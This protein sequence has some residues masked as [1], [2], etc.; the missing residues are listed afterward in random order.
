MPPRRS[1]RI[2]RSASEELT[3][4][5]SGSM[6]TGAA[7]QTN[8]PPIP[9]RF[10]TAYGSDVTPPR[11]LGARRGEQRSILNVIDDILD[12]D[13]SDDLGADVVVDEPE[14]T[15]K[16]VQKRSTRQ[17]APRSSAPPTAPGQASTSAPVPAQVQASTSTS[18]RT[19]PEN[20]ITPSKAKSRGPIRAN[21]PTPQRLAGHLMPVAPT[22]TPHRGILAGSGD[23]PGSS[24][25]TSNPVPQV[26]PT[27]SPF[28]RT[29]GI[30]QDPRK[31][32]GGTNTPGSSV[33]TYG[34]E[35]SLFGAGGVSHGGSSQASPTP[36]RNL[37]AHPGS[38]NNKTPTS[39]LANLYPNLPATTSGITADHASQVSNP[40]ILMP[41]SV[42]NTATHSTRPGES[43]L[44]TEGAPASNP[45]SSARASL[46]NPAT[47][48]KGNVGSSTNFPLAPA[49]RASSESR[50]S[51][52]ELAANMTTSKEQHDTAPH[53]I[54]TTVLPAATRAPA[55]KKAL[56]TK[57]VVQQK[58]VA[59]KKPVKKHQSGPIPATSKPPPQD[60]L[61]VQARKNTTAGIPARQAQPAPLRTRQASSL[62][63]QVSRKPH[64]HTHDVDTELELTDES[65]EDENPQTW[66]TWWSS[67]SQWFQPRR[68]ADTEDDDAVGSDKDNESLLRDDAE[69]ASTSALEWLWHCLSWYFTACFSWLHQ[70]YSSL[71]RAVSR[72][73]RFALHTSFKWI[74]LGLG[75]LAVAMFLHSVLSPSPLVDG[76]WENDRESTR[77]PFYWHGW[78]LSDMTWNLGQFLPLA[79][80]RPSTLFAS[81]DARAYEEKLRSFSHEMH[82]L[83]ASKDLHDVSLAKLE[84]LLPKIIHL[85]L[86]QNGKPRIASEFYY[87]L[88]ELMKRDNEVFTFEADKAG[89]VHIPDAHWQA[90]KSKA[91]SESYLVTESKTQEPA[92][93]RAEIQQMI[94]SDTPN[95]W[96]E[97]AKSNRQKVADVVKNHLPSSEPPS[98]GSG[99]LP[100]DLDD[101]IEEVALQHIARQIADEN[102]SL[103]TRRNFM[104]L[105]KEEFAKDHGHISNEAL[106][107][108]DQAK[109]YVEG[110]LRTSLE[111]NRALMGLSRDEVLHLVNSQIR[112]VIADAGIKAFADGKIAAEWDHD[113]RERVNFLNPNLGA[114]VSP[115]TTPTHKLRGSRSGGFLTQKWKNHPSRRQPRPLDPDEALLGWT[116]AGD[117]WCGSTTYS[118]EGTPQG[119]ALNVILGHRIKPEYLVI[120]HILP[121]ATLAP[122]AR[123]RQIELWVKID[124]WNNRELVRDF[125]A[126]TWPGSLEQP[127]G[128]G[129]VQVSSF[130]YESQAAS[131][132]V[133]VHKLPDE[134][135]GLGVST[136]HVIV[137]LVTNYGDEE[138]TCL[139]RARLFGEAYDPSLADEA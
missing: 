72:A 17:P 25:P 70:V 113:L 26:P 137:R 68:E 116:D 96:T 39:S 124:E 23:L 29:P 79:L 94:K 138:K 36:A 119:V 80:A 51:P 41:S 6:F 54:E 78:S 28:G 44:Q 11:V 52:D 112:K 71:R 95:A 89:Y 99:A 59:P 56:K 22:V 4:D 100:A 103:V 64:A 65:F 115:D 30:D 133:Y 91:N 114:V 88:R 10:S 131:G 73:T 12:A 3:D 108:K 53:G 81:E 121:G 77:L 35:V 97:W 104:F 125:A 101:R 135:K 129:F 109:A 82:H 86:G 85:E 132:G 69:P 90:I 31:F 123:P 66:A 7:V 105:I 74:L 98:S 92:L 63:N 84:S 1:S 38:H 87:A 42:K 5:P 76:I 18:K 111:N 37:Q 62:S 118:H 19:G 50:E 27:S 32:F 67:L 20:L 93:S 102:T 136:E 2:N 16:P 46:K 8:L 45:P 58:N 106:V 134:L 49:P 57:P 83:K 120:D 13:E 40:P 14:P 48:P 33:L 110:L 122:A 128:E 117:C 21:A 61:I 139:Y 55:G 9:S 34:E 43:G 60:P 15:P 127:F 126:Y 47:A 24:A 130:E 75:S 107:L